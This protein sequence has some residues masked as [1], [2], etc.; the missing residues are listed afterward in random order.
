M[1]SVIEELAAS[2]SKAAPGFMDAEGVVLFHVAAGV[3]FKKTIK[4]DE[5]PKGMK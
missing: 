4:K 5:V 2:G 3:G 1:D